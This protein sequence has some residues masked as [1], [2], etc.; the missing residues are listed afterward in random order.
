VVPTNADI[1]DLKQAQM[2]LRQDE[3]ELRQMTD[4]SQLPIIVFSGEGRVLYAN[5]S[6]S[7]MVGVKGN[8]VALS[9]KS[10]FIGLAMFSQPFAAV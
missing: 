1:D 5:D 6:H 8:T 2:N 7:R 3:K 10:F 9:L 4:A